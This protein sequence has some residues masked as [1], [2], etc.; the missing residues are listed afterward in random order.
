MEKIANTIKYKLPCGDLASRRLAIAE[1]HKLEAILS[2]GKT[3]KLDLADVLSLSESYSD[4]IFGVLVVKLGAH[5]VL[6]K[7]RIE[8]ASNSILKS[9]AKVIQRRHHEVITR[10]EVLR[11]ASQETLGKFDA[12]W[13]T[14]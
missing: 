1:R 12:G 6:S 14:A 13:A 4:E 5:A 2:E 3:V 7:V 10:R 8:N 9:I 11:N